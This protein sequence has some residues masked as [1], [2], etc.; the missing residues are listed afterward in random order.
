MPQQKLSN[1]LWAT[2]G[3]SLLG[4]GHRTVPSAYGEYP[5]Q[6]YVCNE[7]GVYNYTAESHSLYQTSLMDKRSD[8]IRHASAPEYLERAPAFFVFCWNSQVGTHNAS[9]SDSGGRFINVGFGCCLQN[10]CLSATAWNISISAPFYTDNYDALRTDLSDLLLPNVY[11]MYLIGLGETYEDKDP[12]LIPDFTTMMFLLI[13][14][15]ST[16]VIFIAKKKMA[17]NKNLNQIRLTTAPSSNW[18]QR[19][20]IRFVQASREP[21]AGNSARKPERSRTSATSAAP[22]APSPV[23]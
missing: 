23:P 15:F 1:M 22:F 9:D 2:Y 5:F 14:L 4:T 7:T 10:L 3:Y 11:P 13:L 8:I 21:F 18:V 20:A 12:P 19:K 6:I 16:M 17:K